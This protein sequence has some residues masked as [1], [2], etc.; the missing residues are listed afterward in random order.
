MP[1]LDDYSGEF[2][3]DMK[4]TDFSKEALIQL[5][6]AAAKC[7]GAQTSY[8]YTAARE[9]YGVET[10]NKL[11]EHVWLKGGASEA[12]L[13]NVCAALKIEGHD[14]ASYFKFIQMT[15]IDATM[16][17]MDFNIIDANHGTLTVKRC[18][19]LALWE[20]LGEKELDLQKNICEVI[21]AK[22][23]PLGGAWFNPRMKVTAIKLPPRRSKKDIACQWEFAID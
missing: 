19:S 16:M 12:E 22:G 2:Q 13:R 8:W 9:L 14:V 5:V 11:Q 3:P 10:A 6:R 4:L 1:E 20:R 21:D 18:Y 15:P 23:F 7:Y 17:D